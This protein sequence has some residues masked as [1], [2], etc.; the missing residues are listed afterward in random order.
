MTHVVVFIGGPAGAGKTTLVSHIAKMFNAAIHR[1][2]QAF[3]VVA[4][5]RAVAP[6]RAFDL[7]YVPELEVWA[8]YRRW[9]EHESLTVG[10]VHYAIQP[11]RDSAAVIGE[12]PREE[13]WAQEQYVPAYTKEFFRYLKQ[14]QIAIGLV[15][16]TVEPAELVR[17]LSDRDGERA[18][19]H[20]A[21]SMAA[22]LAAEEAC[23]AD[24][25]A[26]TKAPALR[27]D[28]TS[29]EIEPTIDV[30]RGFIKQML[31]DARITQC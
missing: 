28:N 4:A 23:F 3:L 16:V 1:P 14:A 20:R 18:R 7:K 27:V 26:A 9:C 12:N 17:R 13:L 22:E 2:H 11:T 10:D 30:V 6:E 31:S 15:L 29:P 5:N 21:S 24:L 25:V 19:S 8:T